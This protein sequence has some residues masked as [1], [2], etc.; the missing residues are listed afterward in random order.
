MDQLRER[1]RYLHYSLRTEKAYCMWVKDYSRFHKLRHPQE[2]GRIEIEQYLSHLANSRKVAASTHKQ[3]FSA[4]LFFY[5]TVLNQNLPWLNEIGR[6]TLPKRLPV[7]LTREEVNSI[8]LQI[9]SLEQRTFAKLL[10]GTG[11]RISEALQSM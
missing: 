4:L 11:L 8:F 3:A 5:G 6:P 9:D 10:Y 1:I 2:M 7:V